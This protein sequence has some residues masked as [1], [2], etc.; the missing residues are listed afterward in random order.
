MQKKISDSYIIQSGDNLTKIA[1]KYNISLDELLEANKDIIKDPNLIYSGVA[2]TIPLSSINI[3]NSSMSDVNNDLN[4]TSNTS[5]GLK[6]GEVDWN[7]GEWMTD[8]DWANCK[9]FKKKISSVLAVSVLDIQK[10]V[11]TRN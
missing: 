11:L 10:L 2:L 7:N 9:Y 6:I 8:E 3:D 1:S 4:S 5:T